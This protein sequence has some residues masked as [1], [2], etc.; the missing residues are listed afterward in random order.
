MSVAAAF[1]A[2]TLVFQDGF[3]AR[4]IGLP[5]PLDGGFPI[6]PVL[7]FCIVFGLSMDYEVFIVARI[8]DGRRAGLPD[9][10][11]LIEGIAGTGRV[12]TFAAAIM[13]TVFGGFVFGDFVLVKIL[14]F[15]L[16][17]AVLVD[18][19]LIRLGVGPGADPARRALELVAGAPRLVGLACSR[20]DRS[21]LHR[22]SYSAIFV[23]CAL[24]CSSRVCSVSV[25]T[26]PPMCLT[27]A[28]GLA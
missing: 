27:I 4:L 9:R 2:V 11:A 3:G 12:I 15:A 8:A 18:A 17:V 7:V 22:P 25:F 10:T 23:N 26:V 20:S 13:M 5:Q 24:A 16:G 14:G 28:P 21:S 1:G 19:S 6:V